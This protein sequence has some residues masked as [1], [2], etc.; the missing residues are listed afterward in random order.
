M[1]H[2]ARDRRMDGRDPLVHGLGNG[3][4]GRMPLAAGAQLDEV[5]RFARVEVEHVADPVAEAERVR[6][7]I[8]ESL[9]LEPVELIARELERPLVRRADPGI[10]D[11]LRETGAQV[12]A[13]SLPLA[14]QQPMPLEVAKATVVGTISNR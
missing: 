9:G 1:G 4:V 10:A 5:H 3:A 2:G 7:G 11:L 6:G 14:G 8:V 12:R 13:Q